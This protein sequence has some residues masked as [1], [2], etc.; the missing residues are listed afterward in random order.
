MSESSPPEWQASREYWQLHG[1]EIYR[2]VGVVPGESKPVLVLP[3]LFGND[4]Y[5]HTVRDWLKRM[6]YQPVASSIAWNVGCPRRLLS[7]AERQLEKALSMSE[8][9]VALV[10]H[11]RG[12]LLAKALATRHADRIRNLVLVGSPLGGM[13]RAGPQGMQAYAD[14]MAN[15]SSQAQRMVFSSGRSFIRM[16]DPD[17]DSPVCQ[18]EYMDAL[19]APLPNHMQVTS[20][21]SRSDPIVPPGMSYMPYG[22]NIVV[23][24]THSGLMF[25][26]E[27]F[28]YLAAALAI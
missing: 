19:F 7:D 5:L 4:L 26:Q 11:S 17:C 24:G 16:L 6:D 28:S 20:I 12:G 15:G 1:S 25:N 13:L 21:F 22:Q 3:G 23:N 18:C 8:G 14:A 2:G 9:D 27:V 10:G